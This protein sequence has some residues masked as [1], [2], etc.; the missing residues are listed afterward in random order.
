L[1]T[2]SAQVCV[3]L[4][5]SSLYL[6]VCAHAQS[7]AGQLKALIHGTLPDS[8]DDDQDDDDDHDDEQEEDEEEESSPVESKSEPTHHTSPDSQLGL[9][10]HSP[11]A[12]QA[13]FTQQQLDTALYGYAK[14]QNQPA[15]GPALSGL[16]PTGLS[17]GIYYI[18]FIGYKILIRATRDHKQDQDISRKD[19]QRLVFRILRG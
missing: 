1:A 4:G 19:A 15:V 3:P 16:R 8:R 6:T 9:S 2:A 11:A 14:P 10:A 12:F 7:L 17:Y 5:H 13:V 18:D